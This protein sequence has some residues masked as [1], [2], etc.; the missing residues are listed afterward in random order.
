[1]KLKK[2]YLVQVP[3]EIKPKREHDGETEDCDKDLTRKT[4]IHQVRK[5]TVR[6]VFKEKN[7]FT[8]GPEQQKSFDAIKSAIANNA[9]SGIDPQVQFHL[10]VDA[11]QVAIGGVLFQLHGVPS[12]TEAS[13]Q[14]GSQERI[15]LFLSF[16]LADAETRYVNSEKEFLAV[17][18]CLSEVKRLVIGSLY[19]VMIDS[20]HTALR[21]IFAKGNSE[22]ARINGWLD[23]LGEFDLKLVLS[24]PLRWCYHF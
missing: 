10:A 20:D 21:D 18:R 11:S 6:K 1:M 3:A 2:A 24:V 19:P 17:V 5:E 22:K 12:G 15:N 9:R 8:W 7:Q 4:K 13:P 23:R 16:K 14:F